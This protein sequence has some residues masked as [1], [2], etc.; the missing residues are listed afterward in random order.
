MTDALNEIRSGERFAFGENW[1]H[2]LALVDD[3]RIRA[4]EQPLREKLGDL[5][6]QTFLDIGSGSGLSSL[7]ARNLGATVLSFDY[8]PQSV[9]CTNELRRRYRPNDTGWDVEQGSALDAAYLD[10]LG[11]FD[12]VYSWGVL[13]HTGDMWTALDL[14]AKRV[15]PGGR[16]WVAIYND[17][18]VP[19]KVWR[20][21]KHAYVTG[22]R[23]QRRAVLFGV[24]MY[25]TARRLVGRNLRRLLGVPSP[26]R[27]RGM[28]AKRDLIDWVGGYPFEVAKP[29]QVFGFYR[30]R[31]FVLD[32]LF[33]CAGGL[34]CNQ[35]VFTRP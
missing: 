26:S 35:F 4:A 7:A 25:L 12:V 8:D 24:T 22:S 21:I 17:Q 3:E 23:M 6:G 15:A 20:A 31:G 32:D 13:H 33:T 28:D 9:A 2:F 27:G 10:G 5:T 19:S 16:L 34:G 18:G 1:S 11:T 30:E 29:E 14:A